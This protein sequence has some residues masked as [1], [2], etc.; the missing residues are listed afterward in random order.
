MKDGL[1]EVAWSKLVERQAAERDPRV[2]QA[3]NLAQVGPKRKQ[4]RR[5]KHAEQPLK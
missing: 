3:F 4:A 1:S 5:L 2:L